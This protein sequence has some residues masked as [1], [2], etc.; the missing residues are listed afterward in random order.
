MYAQR[1]VDY[2]AGQGCATGIYEYATV[3]ALDSGECEQYFY[4]N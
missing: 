2:A 3:L 1:F 4:P